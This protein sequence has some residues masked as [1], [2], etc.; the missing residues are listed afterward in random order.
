MKNV[1]D[2]LTKFSYTPADMLWVT[3][4]KIICGNGIKTRC[5]ALTR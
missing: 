5:D 3:N 2:F 1:T 4:Q